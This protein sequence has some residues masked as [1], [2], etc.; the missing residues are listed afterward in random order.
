MT[1]EEKAKIA[2]KIWG[3]NWCMTTRCNG[4]GEIKVCR[5]RTKRRMLCFVC[6]DQEQT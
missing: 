6:F 5:G 3:E 2:W 1:L 4:C